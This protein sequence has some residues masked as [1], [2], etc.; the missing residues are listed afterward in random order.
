MERI[1]EDAQLTLALESVETQG[2]PEPPL[3]LAFPVA[4]EG[5]VAFDD[6]DRFFEPWWPGARAFLRRSGERLTLRTE[7][8]GDPLLAFPELRGALGAVS[9]DGLVI[10]GTLLALDA[11]G[12]PDTRLLRRVLAG[13]QGPGDLAEGAFVAA[14][15]P[16]L[17]GRSL[18]RRS[19]V[20]RRRLLAAALHDTDH[21]VLGRG[22]VGEGRMLA[23]AVADLGLSALSARR[24]DASWRSG[25]AGDAWLRLT[26]EDVPARPTRP[27]LVL[28]AR[29]P[30]DA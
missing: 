20:E 12:R 16:W 5:G 7:H 27:F 21:C 10:E 17:E 11:E 14:D 13:H 23:R 22:L 26:L 2:R 6:D 18:A 29:L 19:F 28:I 3:D 25:A 24:L 30:L 15:L 4:T 1:D 8:L 9:A